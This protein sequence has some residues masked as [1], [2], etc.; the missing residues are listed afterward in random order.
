MAG[1]QASQAA[2]G[3]YRKTQK[4]NTDDPDVSSV[5]NNQ[6]AITTK[7]ELRWQLKL[8]EETWQEIPTPNNIVYSLLVDRD[9]PLM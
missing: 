7:W 6:T 4:N 8:E 5:V 3:R 1:R 2:N 9:W